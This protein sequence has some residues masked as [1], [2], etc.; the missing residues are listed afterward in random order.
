MSDMQD[1]R[2]LWEGRFGA[3]RLLRRPKERTRDGDGF[4]YFAAE[5]HRAGDGREDLEVFRER[6]SKFISL[7]PACD[8][9]C[10]SC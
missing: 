4:E 1:V 6:M 8:V 3:V 5:Y 7:A 2:E 10:W 9:D